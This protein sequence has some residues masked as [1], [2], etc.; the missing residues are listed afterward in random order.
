METDEPEAGAQ[1]DPPDSNVV[2]FPRDWLGPL[3]ELVPFGPSARKRPS[4]PAPPAPVANATGPE[5][6]N[7]TGPESAKATGPE[8]SDAA[9][10]ESTHA[11]GRLVDFPSPV[12]VRPEDFWGEGSAAI[13]HALEGPKR[14]SNDDDTRRPRDAINAGRRSRDGHPSARANRA[15]GHGDAD[16]PPPWF[17]HGLRRRPGSRPVGRLLTDAW[18]SGVSRSVVLFPR[19]IGHGISTH[20]ARA[21]AS[22]YSASARE[23][24][25]PSSAITP[26]GALTP[27][28]VL[29]IACSALAFLDLG[30][31]PARH[32]PSEATFAGRGSRLL[33]AVGPTVTA[34]ATQLERLP[35]PSH[36]QLSWTPAHQVTHRTAHPAVRAAGAGAGGTTY[37]GAAR[38]NVPSAT[39]ASAPSQSQES[40]DYTS[41]STTESVAE[42]G[43]TVSDSTSGASSGSAGAVHAS[44]RQPATGPVGPGAPFAPGHLG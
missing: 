34:V 16:P 42:T 40:S 22:V 11:T 43:G 30:A 17:G 24:A 44:T 28:L 5:S 18:P 31:T 35:L 21:G 33:A 7:A 25:R 14:E 2:R 8:G 1:Q 26:T 4:P 29:A 13:H 38:E 3:D 37:V 9:G 32:T 41:H 19:R 10:P 6:A 20:G 39:P 12:P 23:S 15:L 27:I 36:L